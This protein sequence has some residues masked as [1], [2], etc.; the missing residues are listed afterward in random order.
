MKIYIEPMPDQGLA[1]RTELI[2]ELPREE[3]ALL[4]PGIPRTEEYINICCICSD[5]RSKEGDWFPLEEES[6]RRNLLETSPIPQLSH[7]YCPQCLAAQLEL[8]NRSTGSA[9]Q[10]APEP[11]ARAEDAPQIPSR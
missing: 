2:E 1:I 8:I 9:P 7:G 3:V 5:V 11:Q 6:V 4:D 10:G